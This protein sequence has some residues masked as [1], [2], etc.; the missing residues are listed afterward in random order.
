MF[1]DIIKKAVDNSSL[2]NTKDDFGLVID[3]KVFKI[4]NEDTLFA[5]F[6]TSFKSNIVLNELKREV[7]FAKKQ[8]IQSFME[9]LIDG[10]K[11]EGGLTRFFTAEVAPDK[12]EQLQ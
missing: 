1:V 8:I 12:R 5:G 4:H 7:G 11:K 2:K 3:K 6:K 9:S 10:S